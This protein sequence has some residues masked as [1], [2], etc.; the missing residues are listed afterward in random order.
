MAFSTKRG[1]PRKEPHAP[2]LGTPE[3]RFKHALGQTTEPIDLCL[4]R[5]LITPEQHWCG[6]HL[7]W[8]H[9]LRHGAARLTTRYHWE[10][11]GIVP[12]DDPGWRAS[13]E[14]EYHDAVLLLRSKRHFDPVMRLTVFNE[15]PPFLDRTL[16]E[17]AWQ[18]PA[19][20]RTLER[21][22]EGVVGGLSLLAEHWR[23]LPGARPGGAA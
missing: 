2:D 11:T 14:R 3:L 22:R 6:L 7:R 19:L 9:T 8:L 13:R 12:V 16:C 23:R 21:S 4:E 10:G 15:L 1:R 5:A 20:S 18:K 17:R